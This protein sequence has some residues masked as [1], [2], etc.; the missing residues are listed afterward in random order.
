[1]IDY[2]PGGQYLVNP[3][4]GALSEPVDG[5][6]ANEGESGYVTVYCNEMM[7]WCGYCITGAGRSAEIIC[8][9]WHGP[10]ETDRH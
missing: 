7:G 8:T 3:Y 6:A 2:L 5:C 10:P 9:L 4:T 1:M